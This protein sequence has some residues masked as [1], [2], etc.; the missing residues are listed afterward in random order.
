MKLLT[1]L[2]VEDFLKRPVWEYPTDDEGYLR[3][4]EKLPVTHLQNRIVG[5]RVQLASG[6]CRWA[7]LGNIDVENERS[8]EH[9]LTLSIENHGNWFDLGRY[10]DADYAT[11]TEPIGRIP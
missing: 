10:H 5:V 11:W 9:F 7:I 3:P 6:Q 1:E 8:T 2:K 4:I